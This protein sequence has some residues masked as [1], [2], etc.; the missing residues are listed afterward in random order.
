M[1]ELN[2][3][4]GFWNTYK[5]TKDEHS[6][7]QD[8]K[9]FVEKFKDRIYFDKITCYKKEM[10]K[11]LE[12]QNSETLFHANIPPGPYLGDLRGSKLFFLLINPG[13]GFMSYYEAENKDIRKEIFNTVYQQNLNEDYPFFLLNPEY[14][15][16]SGGQYW[17]KKFHRL[18]KEISA[19]KDKSYL[20]TLKMFAQ[21]IATIELIPYPSKNIGH[22]KKGMI[23]SLASTQKTL[24]FVH[25]L[26]NQKDIL[27][28]VMRQAGNWKLDK[29]IDC[30]VRAKLLK[31]GAK[32]SQS[33]S[34]NPEKSVGLEVENEI[35]R[36][37]DKGIINF[38]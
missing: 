38:K 7:H 13:F 35:L 33:A 26:L 8:D 20:E 29:I 22:I 21:N 2:D 30:E 14:L 19:K 4:I 27:V 18:I 36:M 1:Q 23:E 5:P 6:I 32:Q 12:T 16:T 34:L 24:S 3:L 28:V 15:W 11:L 31:F 17:H 9:D 25:S 10:E 37:I